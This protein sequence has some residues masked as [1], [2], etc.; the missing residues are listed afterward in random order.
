MS[1]SQM[2]LLALIGVL[3]FVLWSTALHV[4]EYRRSRTVHLWGFKTEGPTAR[5]LIMLRV[6]VYATGL[7]IA[8][9]T[10]LLGRQ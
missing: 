9:S 7:L 5:N 3:V 8:L 6:G 2:L 4:R 10:Y 1:Q